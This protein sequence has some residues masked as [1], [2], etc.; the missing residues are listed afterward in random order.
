M[1]QIVADVDR[2]TERG[3][4]LSGVFGGVLYAQE[5]NFRELKARFLRYMAE[6]PNAEVVYKDRAHRVRFMVNDD[7]NDLIGPNYGDPWLERDENRALLYAM[8]AAIVEEPEIDDI[9]REV[10]RNARNSTLLLN[11][12]TD[13]EIV[14]VA[15]FIEEW[16]T[17]MEWS[18][19]PLGTEV[20]KYFEDRTP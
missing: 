1:T 16:V 2:F 14:N 4:F 5:K 10:L 20:D 8:A 7:L 19:Y 6:N 15:R 17:E 3:D 11:P 12:P 18:G 13:K 9:Q